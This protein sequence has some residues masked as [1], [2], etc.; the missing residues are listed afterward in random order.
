VLVE[1]ARSSGHGLEYAQFE[2]DGFEDGRRDGHRLSLLR[3][4]R[5][6]RH[7]LA[8]V[9]QARERTPKVG[10]GRGRPAW[11]RERVPGGV[12]QEWASRT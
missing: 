1:L 8:V 7:G 10:L 5:R 2:V 9:V 4:R 12:G 11:L 3:E 6:P